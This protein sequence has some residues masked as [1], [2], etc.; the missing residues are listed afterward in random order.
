MLESLK[1]GNS[2]ARMGWNGKGIYIAIQQ[3]D[4]NSKMTAPYIYMDTTG[5]KT[6]N[7]YSPKKLVPWFASQT[8]I[9]ADDWFVL[10]TEELDEIT[11]GNDGHAEITTLGV[12]KNET[13]YDEAKTK[14]NERYY[15]D[16]DGFWQGLYEEFYKSGRLR[17]RCTFKDDKQDGLY[18]QFYEKGQLFTKCTFKN[19]A[20]DGLYER[21]YE[22]GKLIEKYTYKDDKQDGLYEKFYKS[23]KLRERCTFENGLR[24]GLY[25]Q[26][27]ENG[28]LSEKRTYKDDELDGLCELFYENGKLKKKFTY[29]NGH[30]IA[31]K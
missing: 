17:T 30:L 3:P 15:V 26:F 22:S 18:K 27:Y 12:K 24:Q 25:E 13:F 31:K 11:A 8:D 2:A 20:F 19:G 1:K 29:E 23:G 28:Q 7:I 16:K 9:L 21:F 10:A 6:D 14:I 5:L 4:E